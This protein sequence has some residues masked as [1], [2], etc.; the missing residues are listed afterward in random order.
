MYG[1]KVGLFPFPNCRHCLSPK[2]LSAVMKLTILKWKQ[3]VI[4][5]ISFLRGELYFIMDI[6]FLISL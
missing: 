5:V 1:R 4:S 2:L 6:T 3:A